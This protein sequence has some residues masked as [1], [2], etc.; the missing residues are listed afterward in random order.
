MERHFK[1]NKPM[2][3]RLEGRIAKIASELGIAVPRIRLGPTGSMPM[4]WTVWESRLFLPSDSEQWSTPRLNAVL[5]HELVHLKRRDPTW[6]LVALFGRSANWFNPLAWYAV[7]R[8][9]IECERA[10][11]DL[12]GSDTADGRD[13]PCHAGGGTFARGLERTARRGDSFKKSSSHGRGA[14]RGIERC[15]GGASGA[16]QTLETAGFSRSLAENRS[17]LGRGCALF[18]KRGDR[19]RAG[20]WRSA[21]VSAETT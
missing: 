2:P 7:H 1:N 4:V 12:F 17:N 21:K 20:D 15:R 5:L 10:C 18:L 9:R 11:D 8:L 14:G 19:G 3:A 6:F 16:A 13:E